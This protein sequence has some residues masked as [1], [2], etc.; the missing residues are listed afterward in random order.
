LE[1]YLLIKFASSNRIDLLAIFQVTFAEQLK[2]VAISVSV[3]AEISK[4]WWL[5]N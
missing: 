3:M 1:E 5:I 4:E 2:N